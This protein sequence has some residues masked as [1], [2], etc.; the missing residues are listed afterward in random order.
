MFWN[1]PRPRS[2]TALSR[3][4]DLVVEAER[5]DRAS[6][7]PVASATAPDM[8]GVELRSVGVHYKGVAAIHS[9]DLTIRD[10]EFFSLLGPS[11]CGKTSTLNVIG[12]F[13]EPSTGDVLIQD[14]S[15]RHLP[16]YR[17]PVNTVFQSYALFPHM[18]VAENVAFGPR[19]AGQTGP[20]V[21]RRVSESLAL[22]SLAGMEDRR[23][24]QLSG[25]QQQ[26]VAL[27]RA[28]INR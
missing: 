22:V 13:I 4:P 19:M 23:P 18:T 10:G 8:P 21:K 7:R 9:I 11:G 15:V 12:G 14:K 1:V 26:R 6:P 2:T 27:A 3:T 20:D 24:D 25:G 5:P 28:L 16:P 17:R